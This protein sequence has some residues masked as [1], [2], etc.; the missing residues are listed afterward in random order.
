MSFFFFK[1][2]RLESE[3][4]NPQKAKED[5]NVGS[6]FLNFLTF[7]HKF[8][9]IFSRDKKIFNFFYRLS[10]FNPL[11]VNIFTYCETEYDRV[12]S[13]SASPSQVQGL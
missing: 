12:A 10:L 13:L 4:V 7:T 8:I 3:A 5:A 1:G 9:S 11:S 2:S 6:T